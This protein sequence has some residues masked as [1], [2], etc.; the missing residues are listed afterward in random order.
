MEN[1]G[2]NMEINVRLDKIEQTLERLEAALVGDKYNNNGYKSRIEDV[3]N[4]LKKLENNARA[5]LWFFIGAGGLGGAG[6]VK[7]IEFLSK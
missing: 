4:R 5:Q 3:E 1:G 6:I 2:N 7:F